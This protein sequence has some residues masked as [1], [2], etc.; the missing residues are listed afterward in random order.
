MIILHVFSYNYV[1][2]AFSAVVVASNTFLMSTSVI[3]TSTRL[4]NTMIELFT[5]SSTP[6]ISENIRPKLA[7]S[8]KTLGLIT[9]ALAIGPT[10]VIWGQFFSDN[11]FESRYFQTTISSSV[12]L[13]FFTATL[14]LIDD[15]V[16]YAIAKKGTESEK[17]FLKMA[18]EFN[19]LE[20]M[21][22]RFSHRNIGE[23][24]KFLPEDFQ[25]CLLNKF[26]LTRDKLDEY[27][28]PHATDLLLQ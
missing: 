6:S 2:G 9:D 11:I 25:S 18:K 23:L 19:E 8:L 17:E 5:G 16:E 26:E 12:F 14:D 27:L 4:F 22:D 1:A 28:Q 10:I 24:L 3:G 13:I 15:V 21:L 7:F 20:A